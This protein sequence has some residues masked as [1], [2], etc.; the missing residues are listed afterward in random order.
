MKFQQCD[1]EVS[2]R[3]EIERGFLKYAEDTWLFDTQ[4]W[5]EKRA[6]SDLMK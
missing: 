4:D 3:N 2:V 5:N 1:L 6:I